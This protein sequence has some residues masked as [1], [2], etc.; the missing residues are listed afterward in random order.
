MRVDDTRRALSALA[1]A[2]YGDPSRS[3]D[4]IGITGTNG[5]TTTAH[6]IAAIL[7]RRRAFRAASSGRSARS[8][9]RAVAAREH[10]AAAA[11]TAGLLARMREDGARR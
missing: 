3:L 5:K 11:G 10:D 1:A 2:F 7:E 6:M 9:T 4:V 8:S